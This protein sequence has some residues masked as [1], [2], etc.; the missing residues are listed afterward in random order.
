MCTK[1]GWSSTIDYINSFL[2]CYDLHLLGKPP[3]ISKL[4][5]I[6][7]PLN[8]F[9]DGWTTIQHRGQYGNSQDMFARNFSDY[10]NGFGTSGKYQ[11]M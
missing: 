7:M 11:F 3:G 9:T 10:T 8:C 1:I 5:G 2:D 4:N 6:S